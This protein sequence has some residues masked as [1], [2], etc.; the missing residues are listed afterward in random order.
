[1]YPMIGQPNTQP[2]GTIAARSTACAY[3][4]CQPSRRNAT[5]QVI[6]PT[7]V[8]RNSNPPHRAAEVGLR[9][10]EHDLV[11]RKRFQMLTLRTEE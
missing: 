10:S 4:R 6:S 3:P 2:S 8:G 11:R 9:I 1:M 7:V 5:P